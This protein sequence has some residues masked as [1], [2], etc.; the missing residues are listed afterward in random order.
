MNRPL[1]RPGVVAV[2]SSVNGLV[3]GIPAGRGAVVERLTSREN[4]EVISAV[5]TKQVTTGQVTPQDMTEVITGRETEAKNFAAD[6]ASR[7]NTDAVNPSQIGDKQS[8]Y[9]EA[10]EVGKSAKKPASRSERARQAAAVAAE[11]ASTNNDDL[12]GSEHGDDEVAKV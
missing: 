1:T 2:V 3:V 6:I 8:Q 12:V 5:R 9:H 10:K 4:A 7:I 11:A